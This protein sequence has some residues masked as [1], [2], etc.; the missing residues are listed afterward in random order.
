VTYYWHER[1]KDREVL[2]RCA[3]RGDYLQPIP[4][5]HPAALALMERLV[6]QGYF[7]LAKTQPNGARLYAITPAG[8]EEAVR[9]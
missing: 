7:T 6:E 4:P 3:K 2:R 1:G 8:R 9:L 5:A